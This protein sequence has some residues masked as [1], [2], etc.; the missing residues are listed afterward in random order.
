MPSCFRCQGTP[1]CDI[2][3]VNSLFPE[4]PCT[5]QGEL[6]LQYRMRCVD[7]KHCG[8][9]PAHSVPEVKA[10]CPSG[11]FYMSGRCYS[12]SFDS[13]GKSQ[14]T[15]KEASEKCRLQVGTLLPRL[16]SSGR[17]ATHLAVPATGGRTCPPGQPTV[18]ECSILDRTHFD[19]GRAS[20]E[21]RQPGVIHVSELCLREEPPR[22][23]GSRQWGR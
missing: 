10:T 9:Q 7:G 20:V 6:Q 16:F 21:G 1:Y 14:V 15:Q 18:E 5:S 3:D 13:K 8:R 2:P 4:T 23:R 12:I 22:V 11:A 17:T 19:T